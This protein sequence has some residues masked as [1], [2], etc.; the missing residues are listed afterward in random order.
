MRSSLM[1]THEEI[2][3]AAPPY[4][5]LLQSCKRPSESAAPPSTAAPSVLALPSPSAAA[6]ATPS[7]AARP[8]RRAQPA[9]PVRRKPGAPGASD[10]VNHWGSH[11]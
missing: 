10:V 5:T 4:G 9:G 11:E 8:G 2:R 3:R 6:S 7:N 1:N